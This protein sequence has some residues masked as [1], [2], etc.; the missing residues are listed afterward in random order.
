MFFNGFSKEGINFS[1]QNQAVIK[2]I[3]KSDH[4]KGFKKFGDLH[5]SWFNDQNTYV[6]NRFDSEG[7]QINIWYFRD[8][9]YFEYEGSL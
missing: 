5:L 2:L 4:E 9:R 6:I 1:P 3:E 7:G 8:D